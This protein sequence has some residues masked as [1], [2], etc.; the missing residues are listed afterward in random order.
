MVFLL[1]FVL[2]VLAVAVVFFVRE[3]NEIN[4]TTKEF[5]ASMDALHKAIVELREE[6]EAVTK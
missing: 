4:A 6:T 3:R 1:V 5:K 2:L